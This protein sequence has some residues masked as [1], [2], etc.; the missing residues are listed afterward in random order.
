MKITKRVM[1]NVLL[2]T[3]PDDF[4]VS[5]ESQDGALCV[6]AEMVREFLNK[7]IAILNKKASAPRT[8]KP[9]K[10]QKENAALAEKMLAEMENDRFYTSSELAKELPCLVEFK[11]TTQKVSALLSSMVKKGQLDRFYE[12][13]TTYFRKLKEG[14]EVGA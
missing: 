9:T 12:K 2:E 5:V 3:L 14:E 6:D 11:A 1:W 13:R 7:E 8:K 10:Q 4:S